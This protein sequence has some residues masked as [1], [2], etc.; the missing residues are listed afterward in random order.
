M[1]NQIIR[2]KDYSIKGDDVF[3]FDNNIWMYLFCPIG[4][5]NAHKQAEYSKFFQYIV[6]RKNHIFVNSLILSEFANRYLRLDFA[7]QNK[8][9]L[10][11]PSFKKDYMPSPRFVSI[12]GDIKIHLTKILTF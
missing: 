11:Y 10:Q 6:S 2:I 4:Q 12:A 8:S 1:S 5:Y 3:F 7:I 9:S